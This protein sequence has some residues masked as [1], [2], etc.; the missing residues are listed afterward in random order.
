MLNTN[1]QNDIETLLSYTIASADMRFIEIGERRIMLRSKPGFGQVVQGEM[2]G[3]GP[4]CEIDLGEILL[5]YALTCEGWK[6]EKASWESAGLFGV[7]LGRQLA[8]RLCKDSEPDETI[9]FAFTCILN[10]MRVPY[11]IEKT[12][13]RIRFTLAYSPLEETAS[14]MGAYRGIPA[15]QRALIALCRTVVQIAAPSWM[16]I[17]PSRQKTAQSPYRPIRTI[18]LARK[19]VPSQ[20]MANHAK[21]GRHDQKNFN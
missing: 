14:R 3:C 10:S 1:Q 13:D 15:A 2:D 7:R 19:T 6:E 9:G 4:D 18:E 12:K 20:E 16:L 17:R 5:E 11:T 8:V 21:P